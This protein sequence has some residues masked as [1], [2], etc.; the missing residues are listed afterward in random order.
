MVL[1][2]MASTEV[3]SSILLYCYNSFGI[4]SQI[5]PSHTSV[6]AQ[7]LTHWH[8]TTCCN[9]FVPKGQITIFERPEIS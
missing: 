3:L 4:I 2:C 1:V 5:S 8:G 6:F 7:R 9:K